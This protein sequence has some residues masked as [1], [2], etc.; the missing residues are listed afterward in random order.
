MCVYTDRQSHLE[1]R[2]FKRKQMN[3]NALPLFHSTT[4]HTPNFLSS[5]CRAAYLAN[6]SF[7]VWW[8][9][10]GTCD[11]RTWGVGQEFAQ[12]I[13]G[14]YYVVPT[15][16][17]FHCPLFAVSTVTESCHLQKRTNSPLLAPLDT[18][19]RLICGYQS[20]IHLAPRW[21]G[22]VM[23]GNLVLVFHWLGLGGPQ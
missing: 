23:W 22:G 16:S 19:T 13:S 14:Q 11:D 8:R 5:E 4:R 20:T 10:S 12:T 18:V 2:S 6:W 1:I 21:V 17:A 9:N 3:V 7:R 15:A